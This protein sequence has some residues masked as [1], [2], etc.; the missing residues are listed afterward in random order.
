M[1][2]PIRTIQRLAVSALVL[3]VFATAQAGTNN[4][5]NS[6]STEH[7][8]KMSKM[9]FWRHHNANKNAKQNQSKPT[10]TK[11]AQTKTAQTKPAE[12]KVTETKPTET[13]SAAAK[14]PQAT[15]PTKVA[16]RKQP[17][18]TIDQKHTPVKTAV[19]SSNK[20]TAKAASAQPKKLPLKSTTAQNTQDSGKD[21]SKN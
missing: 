13:K 3:S 12:N 21:S 7:H 20:T 17:A 1:N 14:K 5:S 8:S 10:E 16:S 11:T 15:A 6:K 4:T 18:S 2:H 9:A 19:S